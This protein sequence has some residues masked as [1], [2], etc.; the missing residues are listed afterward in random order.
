LSYNTS[1]SNYFKSIRNIPLLSKQ[2]EIELAKKIEKGDIAAKQKMVE[3]NL[4][5]AISIAKKY[6]RYGS[7]LE[8]L[9]QESNIG[10]IKA[11]EKFDWRKGFKF[12]TYATWWIKQAATRHLTANNSLLKVPSHTIANASKVW[13]LYK[14]YQEEFNVEPTIPEISDILGISE[15]HV[16]QAINSLKTRN[17]QSID[18]PVSDENNRTLGDIIPDKSPSVEVL[19]DQEI[20]RNQIV[21]AFKTLSKREEIVLRL[22]FGITDIDLDNKEVYEIKSGKE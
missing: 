21:K 2:E 19:L 10:L 5:L 14:S 7:N 8:D 13:K 20:I 9:I 1:I 16:K 4:R 6:A 15:K 11:V 12:S 22:R 18:K 3:S 17:L